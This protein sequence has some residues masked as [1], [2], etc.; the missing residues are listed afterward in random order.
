M[1]PA[2]T[3]Q[4]EAGDS[5]ARRERIARDSKEVWIN[6]LRPSGTERLCRN[7]L[8]LRVATK[9]K[10]LRVT[11]TCATTEVARG[12]LSPAA[13]TI[14][15]L[16]AQELRHQPQNSASLKDE[17]VLDRLPEITRKK[18]NRLRVQ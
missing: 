5:D 17:R 6:L 9:P 4:H 12:I 1:R 18:A 2:D 7:L 8:S 16:H 14:G 11:F 3:R 13:S 15:F 10:L